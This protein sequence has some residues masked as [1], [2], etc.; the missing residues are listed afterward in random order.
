MQT[1][2]IH[3]SQGEVLAPMGNGVFFRGRRMPIKVIGIS[4]DENTPISVREALVGIKV[5]A[6]F[7][8]ESLESQVGSKFE[9]V[10]P[11]SLLAYAQEVI[12]A[13]KNAGKIEAAE[14]LAKVVLDELDLYVFEPGSFEHMNS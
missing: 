13:L 1:V 11:G 14:T 5:S 4:N 10:P 6:I 3:G 2:M 7:T 8:K 12:E 9:E